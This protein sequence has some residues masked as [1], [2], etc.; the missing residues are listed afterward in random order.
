MLGNS[1]ELSEEF[2]GRIRRERLRVMG[3]REEG[4][5]SEAF[6]L[7]DNTAVHMSLYSTT[8]QSEIN[9]PTYIVD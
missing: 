7:R 9:T 2:P 5:E 6:I 1:V 3:V 4:D 8:D